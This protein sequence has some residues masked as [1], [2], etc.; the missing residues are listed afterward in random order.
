MY[1]VASFGPDRLWNQSVR[2]IGGVPVLA[3]NCSMSPKQ[4]CPCV[5]GAE[6]IE[7]LY[8]SLRMPPLPSMFKNKLTV[9]VLCNVILE[10]SIYD[11][12][13]EFSGIN[14]ATQNVGI[15]GM[16]QPA[17]LQYAPQAGSNE[18][19]KTL[20]FSVPHH[21]VDTTNGPQKVT[22][23]LPAHMAHPGLTTVMV[24]IILNTMLWGQWLGRLI[25]SR[26]WFRELA[27]P[28]DTLCGGEIL[29]FLL[30]FLSSL[31]LVLFLQRK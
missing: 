15:T 4:K 14:A 9:W 8:H 23:T 21:A 11:C 30:I 6:G 25:P 2:K 7:Y 20:T 5:L 22:I 12:Y 17:I 3:I 26:N 10:Y 19:H 18:N 31:S 28:N 13:L 24:S 27:P 16:V 1:Y 29:M